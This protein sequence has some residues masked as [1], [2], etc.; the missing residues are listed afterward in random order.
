MRLESSLES[1]E[2]T[3]EVGVMSEVSKIRRAVPHPQVNRGWGGWIWGVCLYLLRMWAR[4]P[5]GTGKPCFHPNLLQCSCGRFRK[6]R[7]AA[8]GR[9]MQL[10]PLIGKA[11]PRKTTLRDESDWRYWAQKVDK[12]C[13][14]GG[15]SSVFSES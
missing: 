8:V 2:K 6:A 4:S 11:V 5:R 7:R 12:Q 13:L 14:G 9:V 3:V 1:S 10:F 15:F